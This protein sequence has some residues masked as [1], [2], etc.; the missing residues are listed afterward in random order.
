MV[1][2]V[3]WMSGSCTCSPAPQP[4][5][6]SNP[7]AGS[8]LGGMDTVTA[9][10]SAGVAP[11]ELL[12]LP[13]AQ[14]ARIVVQVAARAAAA[15]IAANR[16]A[17]ALDSEAKGRP[18]SCQYYEWQN[19]NTLWE[20]GCCFGGWSAKGVGASS[21]SPCPNAG[22]Q[23][24]HR[25]PWA[26]AAAERKRGRQP[27]GAGERPAVPLLPSIPLSL[28]GDARC[29]A[30]NEK[31]PT[32]CPGWGLR[33]APFAARGWRAASCAR[34]AGPRPLVAVAPQLLVA[35]SRPRRRRTPWSPR[36][37]RGPC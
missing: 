20:G 34:E 8:E 26:F 37:R 3:D 7:A 5:K 10:A 33:C 17:K 11:S 35:P 13:L 14:P 22:C 4:V 32:R 6:G 29:P 1:T 23:A 16:P 15:A 30:S 19:R 27:Q 31:A 21:R 25:P 2:S 18:L 12:T 9:E 36:P 28:A 24:L